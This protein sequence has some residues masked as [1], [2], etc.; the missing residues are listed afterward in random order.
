V[1]ARCKMLREVAAQRDFL[2]PDSSVFYFDTLPDDWP[3]DE[4][5]AHRRPLCEY[6]FFGGPDKTTPFPEEDWF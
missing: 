3:W 6:C 5:I 4:L 1:S 2:K